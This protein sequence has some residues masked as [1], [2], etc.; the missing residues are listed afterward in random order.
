MRLVHFRPAPFPL[1]KKVS[2][3]GAVVKLFLAYV[4]MSCQFT[5]GYFQYYMGYFHYW[6]GG[7]KSGDTGDLSSKGLENFSLFVH[8]KHVPKKMHG[9]GTHVVCTNHTL[10]HTID[11]TMLFHF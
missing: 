8:P 4:Q 2:G 3:N 1:I 6:R 5:V 11:V 9:I 10:D 7:K